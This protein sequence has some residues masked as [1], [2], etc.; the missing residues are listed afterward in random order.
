M[1]KIFAGV[2]TLYISYALSEKQLKRLAILKDETVFMLDFRAETA[3]FVRK[4]FE[5]ETVEK[6]VHNVKSLAVA[7]VGEGITLK[8]SRSTLCLQPIC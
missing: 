3:D 6:V 4:I 7:L 8:M 1:L 2:K 5:D